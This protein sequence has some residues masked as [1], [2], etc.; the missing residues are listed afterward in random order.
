[1]LLNEKYFGGVEEEVK[2]QDF[3]DVT[4]TIS[5]EQI[6]LENGTYSAPV[7]ASSATK[8]TV[9]YFGNEFAHDIDGDDDLDVVFLVTDDGGGSGTFFYVV[10]AIKE[11]DGYRG[12]QA[13]FLG[14]RIAPQSTDAGPGTQVVVNYADRA[15]GEPMSAQPSV[16]KSMYILYNSESNDFGE[17]VQNFEGE[18]NL[19]ANDKANVINVT[20]PQPSATVT[21]PITVSGQARG[22]WFFEASFPLVVTDWDGR[23]IGEGFATADGDWMTEDFVPFMGTIS[24]DLPADTP[25]KRGTLIFKKDNPSGLPEHDDALEIPILFE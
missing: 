14:D 11:T 6:T 18:S 4:F 20:S 17:V 8:R 1:M 12:T 9:R 22:T 23:I 25:Y 13:M 3:K 7:V 19:P 10:G 2:F 15:P 24:Y 16:G 21:N 5:G